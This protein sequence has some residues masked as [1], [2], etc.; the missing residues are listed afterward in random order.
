MKKFLVQKIASL[1]SDGKSALYVIGGIVGVNLLFIVFGIYQET[2]QKTMFFHIR[3][4]MEICFYLAII[5]LFMFIGRLHKKKKI[6]KV[7]ILW[8]CFAILIGCFHI[9]RILT[10]G[11]TQI[12]SFYELAEYKENYIVLISDAPKTETKRIQYAL[13][14]EIERLTMNAGEKVS[15]NVYNGERET[16][17]LYSSGYCINYLYFNNGGH[18]YFEGDD[19]QNALT[20]N[21]EVEIEDCKGD[22]YYITLTNQ[23]ANK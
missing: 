5:L 16:T 17:E 2:L 22:T 15:I 6:S 4:T 11:N 9:P 14:A 19:Y 1:S 18:L 7:F 3:L 8:W 21:E 10:I 12:G 23:K 20:L 13:P